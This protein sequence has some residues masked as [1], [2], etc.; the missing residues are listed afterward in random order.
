MEQ[1][2]FKSEVRLGKY[3]KLY[4]QTILINSLILREARSSSEI[5]DVVTTNDKL[6]KAFSASTQKVDPQTKEVLRYREA[7]WTGYNRLKRRP[8]FTTNLFVDI[9]RIIKFGMSHVHIY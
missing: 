8:V 4:C 2:D 1:V 5:E 9:F 7:L 3:D 6:F